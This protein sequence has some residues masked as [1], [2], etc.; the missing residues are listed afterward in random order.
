MQA[1]DFPRYRSSSV[2]IYPR[3]KEHVKDSNEIALIDGLQIGTESSEIDFFKKDF[4]L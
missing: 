3:D 4:Y 2:P 1:I